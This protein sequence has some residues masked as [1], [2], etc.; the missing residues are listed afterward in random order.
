MGVQVLSNGGIALE[1]YKLTSVDIAFSIFHQ[2][3][4]GL[5]VSE[6][7]YEFEHRDLHIGNI[8]IKECNDPTLH[9][10]LRGDKIDLKVHGVQATIID[11]SLSRAIHN[12]EFT[13]QP[14]VLFQDLDKDEAIFGGK[15]DIQ[16]DVYRD[17]EK[18]FTKGIPNR[19][20]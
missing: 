9:F 16:F 6:S 11:F 2:V 17:M 15:G 3:A 5:A 20:R 4:L 13:L 14:W 8:L 18:Y 10:E 19:W 12:D 1:D 7:R